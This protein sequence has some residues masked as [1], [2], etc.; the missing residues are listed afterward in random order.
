MYIK[1]LCLIFLIKFSFEQT[2]PTIKILSVDDAKC[3]D[4]LGKMEYK[5]KFTCS[6]Y[7][8]IDSYFML[9]Y[10]DSS[11]KK[12]PSIGK[13]SLPKSN[14]I[15]PPDNNGTL[16]PTQE[17]TTTTIPETDEENEGTTSTQTDTITSTQEVTDIETVAD[18][19]KE[20]DAETVIETSGDTDIET[21]MIT[22]LTT[23]QINGTET[24][25][26]DDNLELY[27]SLLR[28]NI[29]DSLGNASMTGSNLYN[30]SLD[31]KVIYDYK[32]K[33]QFKNLL[34]KI[35]E[36]EIKLN[37]FNVK[38]VYVPLDKSINVIL[39]KIKDF[40][41]KKIYDRINKTVCNSKQFIL[42]KINRRKAILEYGQNS[43]NNQIDTLK[44]KV[45]E[46]LNSSLLNDLFSKLTNNTID[47][48]NIPD[49]KDSEL[50]Q[51]ILN[52]NDKIKELRKNGTSELLK[53]IDSF[54]NNIYELMVDYINEVMTKTTNFVINQLLIIQ[55]QLNEIKALRHE[56][57]DT[58]ATAN[59]I[60]K[61]LK[62]SMKENLK[63]IKDNLLDFLENNQL[64][65][66]VI[67]QIK[68]VEKK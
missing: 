25:T 38:N 65:K 42:N 36:M 51:Q 21:D 41:Y 68:S 37:E 58:N 55:G 11:N 6:P 43:L 8:E 63:K 54:Q 2:R 28:G 61:K 29:E 67:D 47:L 3:S 64:I 48:P 52:F 39:Q 30:L 4:T 59:E 26:E 5:A 35:N 31:L 66:P 19:D 18:T 20:T 14:V 50:G 22:E 24:E 56:Y 46:N 17:V 7:Q 12:R 57:K 9:Y 23:E 62:Q 53:K 40:D 10:K 27:L 60:I 44:D 34:D 45:Q 13:L 16:I 15:E 49:L 1:L 33:N 32:V